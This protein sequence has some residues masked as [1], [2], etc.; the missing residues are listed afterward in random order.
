MAGS[1]A[2]H[3]QMVPTMTPN[4]VDMLTDY[5]I[6]EV[7]GEDVIIRLDGAESE[8]ITIGTTSIDSD[9][10][11]GMV[12]T[13]TIQAE[14]E[15]ETV[16]LW[17]R[18]VSGTARRFVAEQVDEQWV[19]HPWESGEGQPAWTPFEAYWQVRDVEGNEVQ[20]MPVALRY[21][22]P[23]RVWTNIELPTVE[24]FIY[25]YEHIYTAEEIANA[26]NRSVG[27]TEL[28]R[29]AAFGNRLSY[30]ADCRILCC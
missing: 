13:T 30:I 23:T 9:Y 21:W 26:L 15:L 22:D 6:S 19:A 5:S 25:N 28:R 4:P 18:F 10:P 11:A 27:G 12:F 8:A 16:L 7:G 2:Q 29:I 17:L 24:A 1:N 3:G 20:T 14:H